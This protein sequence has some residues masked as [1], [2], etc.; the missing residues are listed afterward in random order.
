MPDHQM[1]HCGVDHGFTGCGQILVVFAQMPVATKPTE[2]ALNDPATWQ[3]LAALALIGALHELTHPA[4]DG[5]EPVNELTSR[6]TIGPD[7]LQ[8]LHLCVIS[9]VAR[10]LT[11]RCAPLTLSNAA[12]QR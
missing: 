7:Q 2:S 3:H 9:R 6:A 10:N 5:I 8:T 11:I 1:R 4:A 12:N